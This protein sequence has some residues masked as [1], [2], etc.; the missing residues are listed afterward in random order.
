[1]PELMGY[2]ADLQSIC[3]DDF[4]FD[5]TIGRRPRH[6]VISQVRINLHLDI[7]KAADHLD[8]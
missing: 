3:Y 6:R 4:R 7:R 2:V 5:E 1:M 8:A